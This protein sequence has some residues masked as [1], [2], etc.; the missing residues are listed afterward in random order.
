MAAVIFAGINGRYERMDIDRESFLKFRSSS[1]CRYAMW[2]DFM[3]RQLSDT[4]S[5]M[6]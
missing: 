5:P 2:I 6:S 3:Y 1:V 4:E